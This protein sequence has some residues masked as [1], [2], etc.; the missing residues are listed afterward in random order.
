MESVAK[1]TG[2][3]LAVEGD[4]FADD[5]GIGAEGVSPEVVAEDDVAR[6]GLHVGGSEEAAQERLEA[7]G[8]E[9]V[10]GD[11]GGF[12]TLR[13]FLAGEFHGGVCECGDGSE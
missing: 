6:A 8:R 4:G 7:E 5:V 11:G 13:I 2:V 12:E 3:R 1:P 10:F 9:E